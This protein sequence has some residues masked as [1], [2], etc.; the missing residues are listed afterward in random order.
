M[1]GRTYDTEICSM[2]RALEIAGERWSFLILRNAIF[3][4][5]TRFSEFQRSLDI[6]PNIL[7][8]RLEN[9]VQEGIMINSKGDSSEHSEYRLT[10]KGLDFKPVIMALR[11]WGDRWAAPEGPP[12]VV[13]HEGCGGRVEL[14]L[15]CKKCEA[16]PKLKDVVARPTKS[17]AVYERQL[18]KRK[19]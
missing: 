12:V 10:S 3:A 8:T 4:G 5:L 6:A 16:T 9:F 19:I 7:A 13:E 11:E 18:S 15:V 2:T 1:L 14:R 17:Y